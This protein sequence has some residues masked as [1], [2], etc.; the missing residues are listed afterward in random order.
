[1]FGYYSMDL[2]YFLVLLPLFILSVWA[3]R[4]VNSTYEKYS[5]I[6]NSRGLSGA[7][8]AEMILRANGITNVRVE[9]TGGHLTDHYHPRERVIRLS[10]SVYYGQ[11]MAAVGVAAHE[12]GHA[13]QY[14][15][16]YIPVRLRTLILPAVQ[17]S[18]KWTMILMIIGLILG[19][20][21][22][23]VAG[24]ILFGVVTFFQFVTLPVEFNASRRAL[25]WLQ[26]SGITNSH[27]HQYASSA[28]R[29]AAYTYV[30]AALS[31]LATLL[32]YVMIYMNR[33]D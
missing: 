11:S 3:S 13:V 22:L 2:S 31:S 10:Q 9:M 27:N 7:Q 8:V 26:L 12:A 32:Y 23:A 33:R 17:F 21:Q 25:A 20:Y 15:K 5:Q 18:N 24:L 14:A 29:S 4:N 19:F 6:G 1:M 16:G 28:L 30:V